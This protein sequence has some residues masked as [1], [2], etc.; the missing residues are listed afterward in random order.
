[1]YYLVFC[2]QI[3]GLLLGW[4]SKPTV[5]ACL[6]EKV[7]SFEL[8]IIKHALKVHSENQYLD[9]KCLATKNQKD[10]HKQGA[11]YLAMIG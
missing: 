7:V 8:D 1:M 9:A 5:N 6:Y 11:R 4:D 3:T 10:L 2:E